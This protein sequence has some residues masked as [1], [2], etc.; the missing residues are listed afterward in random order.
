MSLLQNLTTIVQAAFAQAGLPAELGQVVVSQ[1]PE[2]CQFQCNGALA[3]AKQAKKNPREIAAEIAGILGHE[4]VFS[5]VDIAGPGFLNLSLSDDFIARTANDLAGDQRIG[6]AEKAPQ[7][8]IVDFGGPNIAKPMHVGHLRSAVI[9]DALQRIFR[10]AGDNVISDVHMG[11]WGTP[12]GM[13]IMAVARE[14]PGLPYFDEG[15]S[16]EYPSQSPVTLGDL[17]R[18]YPAAA[19][20]CRN[21]EARMDEARMATM[22]LQAGRRGYRAL[23]QHFFDV[24]VA[25]MRDEFDSLGVHFDLWHGEATVNDMVAPLVASLKD[26]GHTRLSDGA[27]VIDVAEADDKHEIP[28]LILVKS[29]GAVTYAATDLATIVDRVRNQDPDLMIYVVDQRQALHFVQVFRA[30]DKTGIA[31]KARFEHTGF[32]TVNGPDGRPFKTREGGVMRLADFIAM[33]RE[34]AERRLND[35]RMAENGPDEERRETARIIALGAVKFADLSNHRTSDY[36]F[37][38]ERFV[39]FEGKTGPYLQYAAVRVKSLL[40]RAG[41]EG[42]MAGTILPPGDASERDL[43][44]QLAS[45]ADAF[46][47]ALRGRAPDRLCTFA[48][49]LAQAFSKFYTACPILPE[50]NKTLRAS[51]LGLAALTLSALELTLDLLGIEIPERM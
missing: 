41:R 13:L 39:S 29:D 44:L 9:G 1:R 35:A 25:A 21:D 34:V 48:Y 43:V 49:G 6:I 5:K 32:G 11:D 40:R 27:L 12:M 30:A 42:V 36:I 50:K 33:A 7:T 15:F 46:E 23:W 18:L 26:G 10:F 14:Q 31:G 8:V 2:L 28:P 47:S 4:D 19:A 17:E 3:A 51:R 16:G 38:P 37:D 45:L 24:S 22:E 20:A